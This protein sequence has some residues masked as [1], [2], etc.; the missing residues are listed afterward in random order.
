MP[1]ARALLIAAAALASG[2]ASAGRTP[3]W[4]SDP[5]L[6]A[7]VMTSTASSPRTAEALQVFRARDDK[8]QLLRAISLFTRAVEEEPADVQALTGLARAYDF[9]AEA[10]LAIEEAPLETRLEA[11]QKSLDYAERG[12]LAADPQFAAKMRAGLSFDDA[13]RELA[14]PAVG[15]AYWYAM[16]GYRF[17][18]AKGLRAR[19]YYQDRLLAV[20]ER[21][22]QL[23]PEY[24][25]GG[26]DRFLGLY[27]LGLSLEGRRD[28]G[29]SEQH[30]NRSLAAAPEFLLTRIAQA[31]TLAIVRDD[32]GLYRQLLEAV[33]AA[34]VGTDPELAPENR[35]A[36]RLAERMLAHIEERF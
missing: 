18:R 5:L 7:A 9:L 22:Q 10:F 24:F 32:E 20:I 4:E 17:A 1:I 3:A 35:T 12:M 6:G 27:Y 19:L 21:V 23:A 26:P 29:R 11:H 30:F 25:F 33:L 34:A 36:K 8:V 13:V 31:D 14:A 2:C 16:A 15:P 28:V